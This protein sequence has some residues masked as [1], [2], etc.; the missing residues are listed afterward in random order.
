MNSVQWNQARHQKKI[1][2]LE[3]NLP[4]KGISGLKWKK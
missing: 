3:S 4:K 2:Y 1:D